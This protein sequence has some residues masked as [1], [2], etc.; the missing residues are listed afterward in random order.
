MPQVELFRVWL[1]CY[2][3]L[4]AS[5]LD[6]YTRAMHVNSQELKKYKMLEGSLYDITDS[7]IIEEMKE[8]YRSIP[9]LRDK[10][11]RGNRMYSRA[12]N[13]FKLF[14]DQYNEQ[15]ISKEITRQDFE[16]DQSLIELS[17]EGQI[18]S[19]DI[20]DTVQ[21]RLSLKL[22]DFKLWPR[23]SGLAKDTIAAAN[24]LCEI[25]NNHKHFISK[26]NKQNYVE[27]HHIIPMEYQEKFEVSLDVYA[28]IVSLCLVCHKILHYGSF[29]DKRMILEK[30]YKLRQKRLENSGICITLNELYGYY[31]D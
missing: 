16:Y 15:L 12:F 23:N 8:K 6:K 25:N 11:E 30:L 1:E 2:T 14:L 18:V 27:A 21:E 4:S 31:Q 28:N 20:V 22:N 13:Y 3:S 29:E 10:D 17:Q 26:F 19:P 24:F 5:T 7:R 9:E